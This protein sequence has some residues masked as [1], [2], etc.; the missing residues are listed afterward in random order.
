MVSKQLPKPEPPNRGLHYFLTTL[1]T[2]AFIAM[3]TSAMMMT[4]NNWRIYQL[5]QIQRQ[6]QQQ[7]ELYLQQLH[8]A[9]KAAAGDEFHYCLELLPNVPTDSLFYLRSHQLR[10]SCSRPVGETWLAQAEA[11]AAT[12]EFRLAVETANHIEDGPLYGQAQQQIKQWSQ[13]I[14]ELAAARYASETDQ[15]EG[16]VEMLQAIPQGSPLYA[17][18]QALIEQWQKEWTDNKRYLSLAT[19]ALE[20]GD[21]EKATQAADQISSHLFWATQRNQVW[22]N[23]QQKEDFFGKAVLQV[24]Q[25]IAADKLTEAAALANQLPDYAPWIYKKADLFDQMHV[26]E[27]DF[28]GRPFLVVV[29]IALFMCVSLKPTTTRK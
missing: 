19:L 6:R 25:L 21:L 20:K 5:L 15:L 7:D 9:E 18:S 24:N 29:A 23:I 10:E 26:L 12:G 3:L 8:Q 14:I 1:L 13:R 28:D 22:V 4:Y 17:D 11:A 2:T 27:K 16:S